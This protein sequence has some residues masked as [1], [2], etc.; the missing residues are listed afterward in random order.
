L[1]LS[2][3]SARGGPSRHVTFRRCEPGELVLPPR[4]QG[5]VPGAG[6]GQARRLR[7]SSIRMVARR[8]LFRMAAGAGERQGV[9]EVR[10]VGVNPMRRNGRRRGCCKSPREA[11]DPWAV[12]TRLVTSRKSDTT[13][14]AVACH[15]VQAA[16]FRQIEVVLGSP[17]NC[18]SRWTTRG[19]GAPVN[20]RLGGWT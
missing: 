7:A 16:G 19:L 9:S 15:R 14:R 3:V 1:T 17:Y 13:H 12:T 4:H 2:R 5:F 18:R 8:R 11:S 6:R 10:Q 20:N